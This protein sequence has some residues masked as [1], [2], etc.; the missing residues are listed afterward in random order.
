M[1]TRNYELD[2]NIFFNKK[3]I[4]IKWISKRLFDNLILLQKK[5]K[6]FFGGGGNITTKQKN[7]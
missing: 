2:I 1:S 3:N 6:Y 7:Q 4:E 5:P